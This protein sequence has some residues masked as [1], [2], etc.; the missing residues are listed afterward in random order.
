M[1]G[2]VILNWRLTLNVLKCYLE[3]V[4]QY[5]NVV[6]DF[7]WCLNFWHLKAQSRKISQF[8]LL[9]KDFLP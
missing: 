2:R 3:K 9:K 4:L 6:T 7:F 5:Y 8:L 1:C